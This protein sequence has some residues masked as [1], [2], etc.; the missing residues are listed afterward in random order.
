MD[1][2][3]TVLEILATSGSAG[4]SEV[5]DEIGVHKST[6][7]RLLAALEEHDLV[8]QSQDRG[9]YELGFG[10]LRL[11]N[12]IPRRLDLVGQARPVMDVLAG[13]LDETI[14][15]AVLRQGFV[16]NVG[17]SIGRSAVAAHNWIGELTPPHATSS[18]KVLLAAMPP[19]ERRTMTKRLD[20]FTPQTI[21]TRGALDRELES[22]AGA[23]YAM[24]HE[25]LE[26]G[27][28]AAAAGVRDHSGA[29]VAALSVSG[30]SYRFD[31]D[32]MR[33]VTSAVCQSADQVSA[34]L[35]WFA[36]NAGA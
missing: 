19:A 3:I 10:V 6:A 30:P 29:I 16:V 11:A 31:E 24:A 27:L 17:Q 14:N 4:V 8:Q 2:A 1:R 36:A 21:T 7:F 32:R 28:L 20:R 18:G 25:E 33:T 5:A 15:I 26:V 9:N 34:R 23:G 13:E 12:S 22:V 35:G